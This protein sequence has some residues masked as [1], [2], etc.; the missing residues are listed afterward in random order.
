MKPIDPGNLNDLLRD[1]AIGLWQ[2][3]VTN[4]AHFVSAFNAQYGHLVSDEQRQHGFNQWLAEA[5]KRM[6]K[7]VGKELKNMKGSLQYDLPMD[8][9]KY[10]IPDTL[11]MTDRWV[12]LHEADE[13]DLD[14][15]LA[16]LLSNADECINRATGFQVFAERVRPVLRAHP[17]WKVGDAIRWLKSQ[18]RDAA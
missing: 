9:Q 1:C 5:G 6:M 2:Q 3:G 12:P 7:R 14:A 18:E 16:E 17:G 8:L 4:A 11:T 15:Y 10:D 13:A